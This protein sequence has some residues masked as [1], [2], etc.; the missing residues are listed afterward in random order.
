M[1]ATAKSSFRAPTLVLHWTLHSM[2][3]AGAVLGMPVDSS[4]LH[5]TWNEC[6][7]VLS[8][9][10]IAMHTEVTN[11]VRALGPPQWWGVT[12]RCVETRVGRQLTT[13][14]GSPPRR[15]LR[16]SCV[17]GAKGWARR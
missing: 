5:S 16:S 15:P 2:L 7:H 14:I 10:V 13:G 8:A 11:V 9:F 3:R 1:A 17:S 6:L 4:E 12:A